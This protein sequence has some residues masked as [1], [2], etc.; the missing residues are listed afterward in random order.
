MADTSAYYVKGQYYATLTDL[1]SDGWPEAELVEVY[2][3]PATRRV[4]TISAL[5]AQYRTAAP[6]SFAGLLR[7]VAVANEGFAERAPSG[8]YQYAVAMITENQPGW[9]PGHWYRTLPEAKIAADAYNRAAG[10]DQ[11]TVLEVQ[12]SSMR[13]GR[14]R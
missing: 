10:H 14:V 3:D 4:S 12:V 13:A 5:R 1:L 7:L 11:D 8:G 6:A 9:A 2:E